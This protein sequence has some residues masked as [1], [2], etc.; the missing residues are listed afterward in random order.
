MNRLRRG[1]SNS[2][3][4]IDAAQNG[5]VARVKAKLRAGKDVN[6]KDEVRAVAAHLRRRHCPASGRA[7]RCANCQR[8]CEPYVARGA[9]AALTRAGGAAVR[10][11]HSGDRCRCCGRRTRATWRWRRCSWTQARRSPP[12]TRFVRP[13]AAPL[14]RRGVAARHTL[15]CLR[16][17]DAQPAG[18]RAGWEAAAPR[19]SVAVLTWGASHAACAQDGRAS[20][21][22]A[23]YQGHL[24]LVKL[25]LARGANV[26]A[27]TA[28]RPSV[29]W[30]RRARFAAASSGRSLARLRRACIRARA[31]RHQRAALALRA[32]ARG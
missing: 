5:D 7:S 16:A 4:L 9:S 13:S 20:L 10:A 30:R 32:V 12:P 14:R 23:A 2:L 25:L 19:S 18:L 26:T 31:A 24:E 27:T 29:S 1:N 17:R 8:R 15:A 22:L 3:G 21:H 6:S 28:V 11:D